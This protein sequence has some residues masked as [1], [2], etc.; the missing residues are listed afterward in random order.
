M[1]LAEVVERAKSERKE[2]KEGEGDVWRRNG[3]ERNKASGSSVSS[4]T[5]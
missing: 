1:C 2:R 3:P 5:R 4:R